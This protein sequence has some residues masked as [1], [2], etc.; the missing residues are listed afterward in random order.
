M[1]TRARTFAVLAA[2][3]FAATSLFAQSH[4]SIGW[5]VVRPGETLQ[6]ITQRYLGTAA[7]WQENWR[8]NPEIRNPNLLKPG[9]RIRVIL[10]RALPEREA[11][12]RQV[13]RHV[14]RKPE[15]TPWTVARA[16]DRLA[17]RHGIRTFAQ[18]SAELRFAD[19]TSLTLT[20]H[21]L[22]FLRESR[23]VTTTRDRSTI[24]IVEGQADLS[25]PASKAER[26]DIEVFM[27]SASV[28]T[29]TTSPKQTKVRLRND[30]DAARLMSYRGGA[31]VSSGGVS[32]PVPEGMGTAAP[33]G[34]APAKPEKLL[35]APRIAPELARRVSPRPTFEWSAVAGAAGYVVE[36]CRDE[37]CARL[38]DRAVDVKSLSW[39]P[40]RMIPAGT[41]YWRVT[42][43][44]AA[45]L[46][47]YPGAA[48]RIE[49]A[50]ISGTVLERGKPAPGTAIAIY[51]DGGDGQPSGTD[52]VRF[53]AAV[54]GKNGEFSFYDLP[55][56]DYW[57]VVD[58]R[59]ILTNAWP[60]QVAGPAGALCADAAAA[61]MKD[62]TRRL[63]AAGA[64]FGGRRAEIS[65]DASTL[66]T[67]EHVAGA[68]VHG[69]EPIV[70][71]F[72]F[73]ADAVTNTRDG[74]DDPASSH[75]SVQG[76]LRQFVINANA[77]A[78]P[79]KMQF[80]PAMPPGEGRLFWTVMFAQPL[81]ELTDDGTTID[82]TAFSPSGGD[83]VLNLN[84]GSFGEPIAIGT[85]ERSLQNPDRAELELDF[86]GAPAGL[87]LTGRS[88][89]QNIALVNAGVQVQ[90]DGVA[91]LE[92]V[93]VGMR[94]DGSLTSKSAS[95][96]GIVVRGRSETTLRRVLVADQ[97]GDGIAVFSPARIDASNLEV[98]RCGLQSG[99]GLSLH[100]DGS[101]IAHSLFQFNQS[102]SRRQNGEEGS[103]I[104]LS[105]DASASATSASRNT[106]Q[107]C[108]FRGNRNGISIGENAARNEIEASVFQDS[109]PR[110]VLIRAAGGIGGNTISRNRFSAASLRPVEIEGA[111]APG[112][113]GDDSSKPQGGLGAP[114]NL[115]RS[116]GNLTGTVCPGVI[117]EIYDGSAGPWEP[118]VTIRAAVDGR[119]SV[120]V[121][122]GPFGVIAVDAAGNASEM[123]VYGSR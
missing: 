18:S 58:S 28:K 110:D 37:R 10:A 6:S 66:Q 26:N 19:N 69:E 81:P 24:E 82:G 67:A 104:S 108:T 4:D 107:D 40:E 65:D 54:T 106:I 78:G 94:A 20:E 59:S 47:G 8:L 57:V 99:H 120:P 102:P 113:C 95:S 36:V 74:D 42:A 64:C 17:E 75:R 15:P 39:K 11:E 87:R 13:A 96:T 61:A 103:G 25:K 33:P 71:D 88:A 29:S 122:G 50:A 76:S 12:I 9:Q 38:I 84:A 68:A 80:A 89:V 123:A 119:F 77:I 105:A 49:V 31:S 44:S 45:G 16:G 5:H 101:R 79:N 1:K 109:N 73:S 48:T 7:A 62:G 21:S 100:S 93:V 97:S 90:C 83:S 92:N 63:T 86:G 115:N 35:P 3:L 51:R 112:T 2:A 118:I 41:S 46:D 70:L 116:D 56:A 27:G 32:V 72:G 14:E 114:A 34:Q 30:T 111:T 85:S 43:R 23:A 117:L 53:A 55:D 98:T 121:S 52:D 22:I 91:R 60:E